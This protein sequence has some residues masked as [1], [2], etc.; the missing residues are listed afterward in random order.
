MGGKN[1]GIKFCRVGS[2][3]YTNQRG[4][5]IL[6]SLYPID[7]T[8]LFTNWNYSYLQ[9]L[10]GENTIPKNENAVFYLTHIIIDG[11]IPAVECGIRLSESNQKFLIVQI[12]LDSKQNAM[13]NISKS[14][15]AA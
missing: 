6:F 7:L 1:N 3:P 15:G 12:K 2:G 10:L 13:Y 11:Y 4:A 9:L 5:G 8:E 14:Y